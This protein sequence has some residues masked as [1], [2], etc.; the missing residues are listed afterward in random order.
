MAIY[1][2]TYTKPLPK[3]AEVYEEDGQRYA[4]WTDRNGRKQKAR[5][6]TG[7]DGSERVLKQ[8]STLT[9]KTRDADGVVRVVNSGCRTKDAARAIEAQL[10]HRTELVKAGVITAAEDKASLHASVPTEEHV[11][12]Y[13]VHLQRVA[14]PHHVR[15][16][17][18][19]LDRVMSECNFRRLA[20]L[21]ASALEGWLALRHSE[22]M[23][24]RT[25][26]TYLAAAKAFAA[27]CVDDGRL[28]SHPLKRIRKDDE[29]SDCRH[30][31]RA[32]TEEEIGRLLV[33]AQL[34]PVAE[35]GR[36]TERTFPDP[37]NPK[38]S[39]W[40]RTPL[41]FDVIAEA[42]D[43]GREVLAKR[44]DVLAMLERRGQERALIYKTLILTG[45]RKGEL[46]SLTAGQVDLD[47]DPAYV[48]LNAADEKN[49]QGA[50]IPLRN[51]LAID[52]KAY[53]ADR[54]TVLRFA[55]GKRARRKQ[56][57][58]DVSAKLF[59]VPQDLHK[60]F[61]RD[62]DVAGIPKRDARGRVVDVHALRTTFCTH[63]CRAGVPLRTAQAAMRH[64]DP[65][66]TANVYTDP[67][68]LDIAGAVSSLPALPL[69][70][71]AT[72]TPETVEVR[73]EGTTCSPVNVTACTRELAPRLAPVSGKRGQSEA[74]CGKRA[75]VGTDPAEVPTS[76]A[77]RSE[78]TH[79]ASPGNGG[80][81]NSL[82]RP[83]RFERVTFSSGG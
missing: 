46:A 14:S 53:L 81:E 27:W 16:V 33:V 45:L 44:P 23:S 58:A 60:V 9:V 4:H 49:R 20:D 73:A 22:G 13:L 83:T 31:R 82:V 12:A 56:P 75:V 17:R 74:I 26:N 11:E 80:Q 2:K 35:Y 72:A 43:R 8:S 19:Q 37:R 54:T 78:C 47:S 10:R 55:N 36:G 52:I 24:A 38:R 67:E 29:K 61:N 59:H 51:D 32:L 15:N 64:S 39:N 65:K 42:A 7:R 41:S 30:Q 77:S 18:H 25:C 57:R 66:L 1:R 69:D 76:V 3:A 48:V 50:T 71:V 6:T 70:T 28:A 62:I 40:R 21:D 63:L 34:R 68:L 79:L 5:V